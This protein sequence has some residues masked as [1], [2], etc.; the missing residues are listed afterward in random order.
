MVRNGF[1]ADDLTGAVLFRFVDDVKPTLFVDEVDGVFGK[2]NDSGSEDIRKILNSGYRKGERVLR[3]GGHNNTEVQTFYPFCPKA[4]A[5]L[6]NILA[7]LAHRSISLALK[8]PL[9]TDR[10][11]DDFDME[12]VEETAAGLRARFQAWA[13]A[14]TS[15]RDKSRKP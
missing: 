9:P 6:K 3:M 1:I 7:T 14:E 5:G 11:E 15:L 4:L 8:P 10:Y 13:D 2:K 12:D